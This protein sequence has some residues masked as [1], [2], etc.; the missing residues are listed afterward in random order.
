MEEPGDERVNLH[1]LLNNILA[2]VESPHVDVQKP[3]AMLAT[4]LDSDPYL[5]RCLIGRV[6]Q[7]TTTVNA[8]VKAINLDGETVETGRPDKATTF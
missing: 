8:S 4:L 1:P 7:G 3:F 5:G 2:H 6:I